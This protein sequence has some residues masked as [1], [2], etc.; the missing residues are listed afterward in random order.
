MLLS[1]IIPTYNEVQNIEQ[2]L[3]IIQA[4]KYYKN[5]EVIVVDGGSTDGT[6]AI[7]NGFNI[8]VLQSPQKGR[9][10]Q[11]NYGAARAKGEALYFVHADVKIQAQYYEQIKSAIQA[12]VA[13]GCYQYDFDSKSKLLKFNA[14]MTRFNSVWAGGGDQTLFLKKETFTLLRGFKEDFIIMEDFDLIKRAKQLKLHFKILPYK[15]IVSARKFEKNSWLKV[16][17]ANAV[18]VVA[19]KLGASQSWMKRKYVKWLR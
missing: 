13:L 14:Y 9:A 3:T 19:W 16:Q 10:V 1:I 11:M 17:F 15:V 2:L 6:L 18:I 7:V 4:N 8:I 5:C 12:D